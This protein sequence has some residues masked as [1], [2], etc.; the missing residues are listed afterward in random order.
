MI[1]TT[2][3][4][5][6]RT[7]TL[8]RPER[9]NALTAAGLERLRG[10]LADATEPV[11]L[12]RGAGDAFCAGADLDEVRALA[13]GEEARAFAELGQSVARELASHDGA[14]VAGIDGP[15]RGGGVELALACD[16]RVCTARSTFAETG[17]AI[18]LFGAWGGTV[19]LPAIVGRGGALDLA[20]TAREVDAEGARRLGLVSQIVDEPAA[21]AREVAANDAQ[22]VRAVVELLRAERDE[23]WIEAQ[24]A[25]E[26]DAFAALVADGRPIRKD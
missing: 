17:V 25:R 19:R 3:A 22:A 20:L 1:R 21:V 10:I 12:L 26:R 24:E 14:V 16:L 7:I 15:A 18:G 23:A 13:D 6:V 11:L 2:T 4:G 9:R 8:D 5:N